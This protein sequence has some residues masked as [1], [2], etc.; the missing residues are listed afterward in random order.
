[1]YNIL[2]PS[3]ISF[4]LFPFYFVCCTNDTFTLFFPNVQVNSLISPVIDLAI[5]VAT[6]IFPN[7]S[8]LGFEASPSL[9]Q[10]AG[11]PRW[12][13]FASHT[14]AILDTRD[15]RSSVIKKKSNEHLKKTPARVNDVAFLYYS[16]CEFLRR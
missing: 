5:Y 16:Y 8:P 15:W 7:V 11:A 12:F 13:D 9:G 1:M 2:Y 6:P 14:K 10:D 4:A 3:L